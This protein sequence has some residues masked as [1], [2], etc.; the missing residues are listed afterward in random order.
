MSATVMHTPSG[1]HMERAKHNFLHNNMQP[2]ITQ[3]KTRFS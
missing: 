1:Q 3:I 2:D